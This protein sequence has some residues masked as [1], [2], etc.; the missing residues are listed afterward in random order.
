MKRLEF[1]AENV[2]QVV[3]AQRI[4]HGPPRPRGAQQKQTTKTTIKDDVGDIRISSF[5]P[6]HDT[7]SNTRREIHH[8]LRRTVDEKNAEKYTQRKTRSRNTRRE[9]HA[10]EIHDEK[11]TYG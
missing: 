6:G 11:Y 8:R 3:G 1:K 9:I 5:R 7:T 4:G 2:T 10:V